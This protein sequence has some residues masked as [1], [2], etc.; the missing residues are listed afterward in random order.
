MECRSAEIMPEDNTFPRTNRL[1]SSAEFK[2]VFSKGTKIGGAFFNVF[3]L[4]NELNHGR[5]GL[6]VSKRNVRRSVD[7]SRV[8]RQIRE[9]F[10][11]HPRQL[12]GF[13]IVVLA[14]RTVLDVDNATLAKQ[15]DRQWLK[16][17]QRCKKR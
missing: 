8:K 2:S 6:A 5:L 12:E 10:R 3:A 16:V 13:D 1:L 7:R 11:L 9:N 17:A 4:P 15:L 14:K